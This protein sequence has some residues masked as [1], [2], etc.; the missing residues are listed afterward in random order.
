MNTLF[1]KM[2]SGAG[3][4]AFE[5]DK[6]RRVTLIQSELRGL[7]DGFN[8]A[9]GQAGTVA[10]TVY[11]RGEINQPELRA[12]CEQAAAV[13][14]QVNAKEAEIE[15]IRS[16][17]YVE[18]AITYPPGTLL[19][20]AGHGPLPVGTR[21][22][23]H[24]GQ[25][26]VA[27][28]PVAAAPAAALCPDCGQP[29]PPGARFCNNCGHPVGAAPAPPQPPAAI[30]NPNLPETVRLSGPTAAVLCPSCGAARADSEAAVCATC[31]FTF[32]PAG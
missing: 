20:P 32:A 12:A 29:L 4:A 31:G 14:A 23:E 2:R 18:P 11:Q 9:L 16:E 19:C 6:L 26:G 17:Q 8:K 28:A 5:A 21:F 27:P 7:R 30:P 15:R 22:C 13:L 10:L 25:P 1:D 24:C 3:K